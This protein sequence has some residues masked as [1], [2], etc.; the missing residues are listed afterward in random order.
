MFGKRGGGQ[1]VPP[2]VHDAH[3]PPIIV[4]LVAVVRGAHGGLAATLDG[5]ADNAVDAALR[6]SYSLGRRSDDIVGLVQLVVNVLVV[7]SVQAG[8]ALRWIEDM[9]QLRSGNS[10][11]RQVCNCADDSGAGDV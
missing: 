7:V 1:P 5:C 8:A 4:E 6:R 11:L 10:I 9:N 2:L 3:A